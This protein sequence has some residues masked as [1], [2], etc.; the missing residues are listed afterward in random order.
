MNKFYVTKEITEKLKDKGYP[1]ILRQKLGSE[2]RYSVRSP[3]AE[4][5]TYYEH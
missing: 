5:A 2:C 3:N 1:I 4:P